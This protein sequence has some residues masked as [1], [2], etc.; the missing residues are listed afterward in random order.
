MTMTKEEV[1]QRSEDII[2]MLTKKFEDAIDVGPD[3]A[4]H[5]FTTIAF[6]LGSLIP[7]SMK[8]SGYGPMIAQ[9]LDSLTSGVQAGIEASKSEVTFIK[10]VKR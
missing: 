4:E 6:T 5:F 1:E 9:L 10:V 3:Q 8:P 7:I 2:R